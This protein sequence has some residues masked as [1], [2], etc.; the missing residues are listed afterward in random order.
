MFLLRQLIG[1]WVTRSEDRFWA[2]GVPM[3]R[4]SENRVMYAHLAMWTQASALP[5]TLFL[6]DERLFY[7]LFDSSGSYSSSVLV[8]ELADVR[9]GRPVDGP[10]GEFV[11][12]LRREG[13][14]KPLVLRPRRALTSELLAEQMYDKLRTLAR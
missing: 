11:V 14:E 1:N 9:L 2:A 10:R 7:R 4:S 13:V 3:I 6:T 5:G 8:E 12:V